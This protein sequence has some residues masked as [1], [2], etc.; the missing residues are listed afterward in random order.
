MERIILFRR[1]NSKNLLQSYHC[2]IND[3]DESLL[4]GKYL[5][6]I[7]DL[8]VLV[9]SLVKNLDQISIKNLT[10]EDTSIELDKNKE[11]TLFIVEPLSTNEYEAFWNSMKRN[12]PKTS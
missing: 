11:L 4:D 6:N 10:V 8:S 1:R 12:F 9:T 3:K 2:N 5:E 7:H